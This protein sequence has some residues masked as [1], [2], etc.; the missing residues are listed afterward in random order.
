MPTYDGTI[1]HSRSDEEGVIDVV[2][3]A[4]IRTLYFGT[5]ARQ[6]T[7]F[8]R[9]PNALALAYTKCVMTSL[10]F[11]EEPRAV[12]LLGLGG[13]SLAK[14]FLHQFPA[15]RVD[16]VEKRAQVVG[17]AQTYFHLPTNERIKVQVGDAVDFL[18]QEGSGEY[19]LVMVD[20]HNPDGMAPV[21]SEDD[22]FSLCQSRLQQRGILAINLWTGVRE[23]VLQRTVEN[24]NRSFPHGVLHLP[25]SGKRNTVA[26][27]F[28]FP[29]P[30]NQIKALRRRA[31]ELEEKTD[32]EL[33]KLLWELAR[34]NS[35]YF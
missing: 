34:F 21:V 23:K 13:G 26:L 11:I 29:V 33:T 6:S 22:F 24:L 32:L 3:E 1:I 14:F 5:R 2:D 8:L 12:L 28:N 35:P 27:A 25:V 4:T 9:D 15:C 30:K 18:R 20:L 7:M 10:V 19:D 17:V 16:A 31:V